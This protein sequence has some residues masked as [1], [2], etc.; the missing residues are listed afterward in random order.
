MRFEF[1]DGGRQYHVAEAESDVIRQGDGGPA[2]LYR[3]VTR[4][5]DGAQV[6][7]YEDRNSTRLM[8]QLEIRGEAL[9]LFRGLDA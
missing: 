1:E 3:L 9:R 5:K 8:T 7:V 2:Q 6:R 4:I